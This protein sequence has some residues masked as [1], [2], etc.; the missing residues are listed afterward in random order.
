MY[1]F[2]STILSTYKKGLTE[3]AEKHRIGED[4]VMF[5]YK[6]GNLLRIVA[7]SFM[8]QLPQMAS[9]LLEEFYNRDFSRS[10]ADFS[11][12]LNPAVP[13]WA[14]RLAEVTDLAF[15]LQLQIKALFNTNY[16]QFFEFFRYS[17]EYQRGIME[18][19]L[20]K[21]Q[22]ISGLH[23]PKNKTFYGKSVIGFSIVGTSITCLDVQWQQHAARLPRSKVQDRLTY[24]DGL[25]GKVVTQEIPSDVTTMMYTSRNTTLKF[26]STA[27][28]Q[29]EFH[30]ARTK[31]G[32]EI[33]TYDASS[34]TIAG[35]TVGGELIDCSIAMQ[36]LEEFFRNRDTYI[37]LY[38]VKSLDSAHVVRSLAFHG[39]TVAYIVKDLQLI[40]FESQ[41]VPW[42]DNKYK[43]R[44]NRLFFL[45]Y[46]LLSVEVID[47]AR[48]VEIM[49]SLKLL[50]GSLS[51]PN[52]DTKELKF[53]AGQRTVT[54]FA[55][56]LRELYR[57]YTIPGLDQEAML[58]FVRTLDANAAVCLSVA[59]QTQEFLRQSATIPLSGIYRQGRSLF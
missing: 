39:Y 23:D 11:I 44:V 37:S 53:L 28:T 14:Q 58:G 43:K 32:F 15:Q 45:N 8:A 29:V 2:M 55:R 25:S 33:Y 46:L 7:E 31:V 30:L 54:A 27:G 38:D 17:P 47:E 57:L 12:Y 36:H 4:D 9:H 22:S 48:R 24:N 5:I 42:G 41:I 59:V 18:E 40:L 50:L 56:L 26:M 21:F 35:H 3:F 13:N 10:D 16:A 19:Y 34:S 49:R 20:R 1:L 51:V 52:P 6:G